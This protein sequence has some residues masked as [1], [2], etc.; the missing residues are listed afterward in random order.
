M[1]QL[2]V[3]HATGLR[4]FLTCR[5]GDD[6]ESPGYQSKAHRD[7][8]STPS[9][10]SRHPAGSRETAP[11]WGA[12]HEACLVHPLTKQTALSAKSALLQEP[13]RVAHSQS[14]NSPKAAQA[15][16]LEL[17]PIG[18]SPSQDRQ[19]AVKPPVLSHAA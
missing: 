4:D 2:V 17:G 13:D 3:D 9:R 1:A 12:G 8:S 7:E 19:A 5:Q 16:A 11:Y 10:R 18:M 14:F 6:A 15:S